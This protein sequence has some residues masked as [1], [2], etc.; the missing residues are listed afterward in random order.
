MIGQPR[1]VCDGGENIFVLKKRIILQNFRMARSV[2]QKIEDIRHAHSFSTNARPAAA[3]ARLHGD[4]FQKIHVV[5]IARRAPMINHAGGKKIMNGSQPFEQIIPG[6][7]QSLAQLGEHRDGGGLGAALDL[8]K[9]TPAQIGFLG[10]RL[11]RQTG[12]HAQ[13]IDIFSK[14]LADTGSHPCSLA[15]TAISES[16]L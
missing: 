6:A 13:T 5:T 15:A 3:L 16:A 8:L 12:R 2:A 7:I 9:I 10:K 11:L 14:N 4:A 1:G